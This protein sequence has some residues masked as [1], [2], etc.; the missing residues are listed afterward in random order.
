MR[1]G[2]SFDDSALSS[3]FDWG[4][5]LVQ[6][7]S[8]ILESPDRTERVIIAQRSDE[9]YTFRRQWRTIGN[10]SADFAG[11]GWGAPGPDCGIY[12]SAETAETEARQRVAWLRDR[13][14]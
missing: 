7:R 12:D 10:E 4:T 8:K 5:R 1:Q 3:R 6:P 13:F 14:H 2:I 11:E 9:T